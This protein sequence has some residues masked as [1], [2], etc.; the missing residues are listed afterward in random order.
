MRMETRR[1]PVTDELR[2][3]DEADDCNQDSPHDVP[4]QEV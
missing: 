4:P 3:S 1:L 2:Q